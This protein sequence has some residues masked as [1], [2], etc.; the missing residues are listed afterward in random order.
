MRPIIILIIYFT[1]NIFSYSAEKVV[2]IDLLK[3]SSLT[4]HGTSNV[5][6]FKLSQKGDFLTTNELQ[7]PIIKGQNRFTIGA[8]QLLVPVNNFTSDNRMAVR[9]F[10]KLMKSDQYPTL[11]LQVMS[12]DLSPGAEKAVCFSGNS[13]VNITITG[14]SRTYPISFSVECE[15]DLYIITGKKRINIRDFGLQPPTE[16]MGLIKVNEWI[17]V[18]FHLICKIKDVL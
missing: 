2:M 9:D 17:E 1:I 18:D 12:V 3:S 15:N 5:V 11:S 13:M 7:L 6:S 10:R 8:N 14:V 16:M 4:V